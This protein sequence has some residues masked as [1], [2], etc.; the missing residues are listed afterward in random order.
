MGEVRSLQAGTAR[1]GEEGGGG[2]GCP[3]DDAG[4]LVLYFAD[5]IK[6]GLG[7]SA[8]YCHAILKYWSDS[9]SIQSL[10]SHSICSPCR[11][12]QLLHEGKSHLGSG[13]S[14]FGLLFPGQPLV[15][16]HP[17]VGGVVLSKQS[18][19][20]DMQGGLLFLC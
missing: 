6:V 19:A 13:F 4:C 17:Q 14:L 8:P 3:C 2:G 12:C 18:L 1:H 11:A 16:R 10:E 15:E 7:C 5:R 20:V 9:T